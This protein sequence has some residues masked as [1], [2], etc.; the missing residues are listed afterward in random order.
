MTDFKTIAAY[1]RSV[2]AYADFTANEPPHPT[3]ISFAARVTPGG[4]ILDL[5]CGPAQASAFLRA[6]GFDV[7]PVDASP[8]MVKLANSTL[9]IAARQAEFGD[10]RVH[11]CYD[12]IWANFSLLHAPAD[13]LPGL[14]RNLHHALT[15]NGIFHIAMKLGEGA[16][17]DKLDRFYT[18]Y[19]QDA[20]ERHL[21]TAG[22]AVI[23][24]VLGEDRGLAGD[25]EPWIAVTCAQQPSEAH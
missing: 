19:S 18:Y 20:L 25:I 14:L 1:D 4:T 12:G 23:D 11:G 8:E 13:Q 7:D 24:T 22:F 16:R 6:R 21:S 2:A 5:G 3:L 10:I 9:N 15:A 17:R